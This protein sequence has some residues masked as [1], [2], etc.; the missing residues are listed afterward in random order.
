MAKDRGYKSIVG[1][2]KNIGF[3]IAPNT[4][5]RILIDHGIEPAPERRKKT[6]WNQFLRIHWDSIAGAD[7]FTTEVWT[8]SGLVTYYTFF[9]V[10]LSTRRVYIAPPTVSPNHA[11]MKQIAIELTA[12]DDS[13]LRGMSYL[14]IDR[15]SKYTD[16]FRALLKDEGVD[17]VRIPARSPNCNPIAE[18]FVRS[19]K[20]DCLER[21][22]LFGRKA[23]VRATREYII[24]FHGERNHQGL[25]NDLIEPGPEVGEVAGEIE[26]KERLGGL[27]NYYYRTAA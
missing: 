15:D 9:V 3:R 24:Y 1:R 19:I 27:L 17:S 14:I 10:Q 13:F 16:Q 18:R 6:T 12:F 4:V 23:L 22:I 20:E 7:F 2:L 25:G 5:K 8:W 26:R 11:F 21:M